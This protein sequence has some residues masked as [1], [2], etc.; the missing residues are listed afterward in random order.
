[1]SAVCRQSGSGAAHAAAAQ[2]AAGT[3]VVSRPMSPT[4]RQHFV[5]GRHAFGFLAVS[6][7]ASAIGYRHREDSAED[8]ARVRSA[9]AARA[10]R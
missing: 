10:D 6:R 8:A 1:M 3:L 2:V 7:L 4:G 9:L 5:Q